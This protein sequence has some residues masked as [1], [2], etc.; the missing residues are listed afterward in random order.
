[1]LWRDAWKL[2]DALRC[3]G[4]RR[5]VG[6]L[7][8]PPMF[9]CQHSF[10]NPSISSPHRDFF[11]P[12][13]LNFSQHWL[14]LPLLSS[15]II[16]DF[17]SVRLRTPSSPAW[18]PSIPTHHSV[19]GNHRNRMTRHWPHR[20][21]NYTK[22]EFTNH[23]THCRQKHVWPYPPSAPRPHGFGI[24]MHLLGPCKSTL[25]KPACTLGSY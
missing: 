21:A 7:S 14:L 11:F 25:N 1:M 2:V 5:G 6:V 4:L 16:L 20:T 17:G 24:N 13:K 19:G 10:S 12:S 8:F 9:L 23:D 22:H 15:L 18:T 3:W